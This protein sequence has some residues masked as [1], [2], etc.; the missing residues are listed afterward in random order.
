MAWYLTADGGF[1]FFLK[2]KMARENDANYFLNKKKLK[3]AGETNS[4]DLKARF[5]QPVIDF[6]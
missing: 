2:N 6:I 3:A 5:G 4:H 1:N